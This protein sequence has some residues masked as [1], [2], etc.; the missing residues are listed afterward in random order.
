MVNNEPPDEAYPMEWPHQ[1]DT[2]DPGTLEEL[3][4]GNLTNLATIEP[5]PPNGGYGW[6]CMMAVFLINAHTWG[7]NA[8]RHPY[9]LLVDSMH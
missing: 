8:V 7:V 4:N 9:L 6:V 5:I 2:P 3:R 1:E